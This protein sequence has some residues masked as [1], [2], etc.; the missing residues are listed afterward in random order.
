MID[1]SKL[2]FRAK[3]GLVTSKPQPCLI[4]GGIVDPVA[5]T[6]SVLFSIDSEYGLAHRDCAYPNRLVRGGVTGTPPKT[7]GT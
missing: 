3:I 5:V 1:D 6:C 7:Y 2:T 4:C